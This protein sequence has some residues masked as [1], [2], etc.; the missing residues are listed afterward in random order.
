M[1]PDDVEKA[2]TY[3]K[4]IDEDTSVG[5]QYIHPV[6]NFAKRKET[7]EAAVLDERDAKHPKYSFDGDHQICPVDKVD[8]GVHLIS[9]AAELVSAAD[10]VDAAGHE[11]SAGTHAFHADHAAHGRNNED[12]LND[13]LK[14]MNNRFNSM[15]RDLQTIRREL[16][17]TRREFQSTQRQ[18]RSIMKKFE[19]TFPKTDIAKTISVNTLTVNTNLI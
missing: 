2:A 17:S 10:H 7:K 12:Q 3:W 9:A 13:A 4:G 11:T 14:K 16:R 6:Y 5:P 15:R 18:V 19:T 1:E 8:E